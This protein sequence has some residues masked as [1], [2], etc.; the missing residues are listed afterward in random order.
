MEKT[1]E[2]GWVSLPKLPQPH[3]LIERC[4]TSLEG[5]IYT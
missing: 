2:N 5:T 3:A 1:D 4:A